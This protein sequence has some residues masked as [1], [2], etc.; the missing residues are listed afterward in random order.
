MISIDHLPRFTPLYALSGGSGSRFIAALFCAFFIGRFVT[1]WTRDS[2]FPPVA[3][4]ALSTQLLGDVADDVL[5]AIVTLWV[6]TFVDDG[7]QF[8]RPRSRCRKPPLWRLTNFEEALTIVNAIN[9]EERF[10]AVSVNPNTQAGRFLVPDQ[11]R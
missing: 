7:A 4:L 3:L 5:D 11:I 2:I 6:V 8:L 1:G 9:E 10:R